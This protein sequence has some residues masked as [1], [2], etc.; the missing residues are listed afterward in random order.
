MSWP[1][2]TTPTA[3]SSPTWRR[4]VGDA[5]RFDRKGLV[6]VDPLRMA[7][8]ATIPL[9]IGYLAGSWATGAAAAGGALSVGIG[10][11][12]PSVRPRYALLASTAAG[13][14]VGTF[15]GC[16]TSAH[17]VLHVVAG[18][19]LAFVG[20][21][22]VAVQPNFTGV[23]VNTL[24]AFLVYGRFSA[25]PLISLRTAGFVAAGGLLQLVLVV[26]S[27]RRPRAG[28]AVHGLSLAYRELA[29]LARDLRVDRSS[30]PA[31]QAIDAAGVDLDFSF[32]TAAGEAWTSLAAEA[33]RVR[34]E[35]LSLA[36]ARSSFERSDDERSGGLADLGERAAHFLDC[37][38]DSLA[39]V[40]VS[41]ECDNA[42][43]RVEDA[44]AALDANRVS[45]RV[46]SSDDGRDGRRFAAVRAGAAAQALAGQ[47]RAISAL[48]P[49]AVNASGDG[50]RPIAALRSATR[51]SRRGVRGVE[52][53]AQ[54]MIANITPRSDAFTH[55]LRLVVVVTIATTLAHLVDLGRGY[56]LALTTVLILRPEFAITFTRGVARAAGTLLGVAAA[57]GI[58]VA[59][60][61][62]GW[63]LV[64]L[65]AASIW[66]SGALFSASYALFSIA[67][68]GVV[69]FLLEGIDR[70]PV[71]TGE[72]RLLSTVLGAALALLSY[73]VW[74]TW[75]RRPA[76]D[77][78]ADLADATHR[79]AVAVL[80]SYLHPTSESGSP[81]ALSALSRAVRLARTNCEAALARSLAD[82]GA[83]Q[84]D[85]QTTAQL[86]AA[87]RRISITAHTMRLRRPDDAST[88]LTMSGRQLDALT[89][90]VDV[91]LGG[92]AAR[93]RFGQVTRRHE[94]LRDRHQA[95]LTSVMGGTDASGRTDPASALVVAETDELVDATNSLNAVLDSEE[96]E[97]HMLRDAARRAV[98]T[99]IARPTKSQ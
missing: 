76:A 78:L 67:I 21:L 15:V 20:G 87:L 62:H 80:R 82:P 93:L 45:S 25:S 68:T 1:Q 55:A 61:P 30:L 33:H 97:R 85:A 19:V 47:L 70:H 59:A 58:A 2:E 18:A 37:V 65:V 57:T 74:P 77:A 32:Q 39:S 13:M 60:N 41:P 71:T 9:I 26:A 52:A 72:D 8:G 22:L 54:R 81:A 5:L 43:D 79:Y 92:A 73:V 50:L 56:W 83:R 23:G 95:L 98:T 3:K 40:D 44:V 94:P 66:L 42:L 14:A 89:K 46:T 86:L 11:V 75:G 7:V 12:I 27:R 28:R 31:A 63:L 16:A 84:L 29:A 88:L 64:G 96:S 38:A 36:S 24:V 48:L 99:T 51:V 53:I 35:L 4:V 34:L 49:D 6:F 91:E 10:S 69:V 90:S 17:S